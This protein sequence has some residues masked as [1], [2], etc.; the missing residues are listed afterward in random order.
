MKIEFDNLSK[1]GLRELGKVCRAEIARRR[2]GQKP[3]TLTAAIAAEWECG[4][5][6][7]TNEECY[8]CPF[9]IASQRVITDLWEMAA[10]RVTRV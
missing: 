3:R 8:G 9:Y 10:C 2:S 1:S 4:D 5:C 7:N 6:A